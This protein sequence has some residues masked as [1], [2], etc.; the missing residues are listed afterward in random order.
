M[1]Q[2]G[3]VVLILGGGT[4]FGFAIARSFVR[5]ST[6]TIIILG[7]RAQVLAKAAS[8]FEGEAQAVGTS[9]TIITYTCDVVNLAEVDAVWKEIGAQ[10]FTVD[11]FIANVA[12][13]TEPKPLLDL[14]IDEV[15][16]QVET[17]V[18]SSLYFFEKFYSQPGEKQR[19]I[20]YSLPFNIH[21][22]S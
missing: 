11:V 6:D 8:H 2:A 7:H 5:T 10:G 22:C 1:S 18:K 13:I 15:W 3:R 14:G 4:G 9:T 19:A 20:I 16:S 12:W 21:L 17:N